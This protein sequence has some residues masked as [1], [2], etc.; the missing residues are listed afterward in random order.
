MDHIVSP[1]SDLEQNAT[2]HIRLD[3]NYHQEQEQPIAP[4]HL[5]QSKTKFYTPINPAKK[6]FLNPSGG[7]RKEGDQLVIVQIDN[8]SERHPSSQ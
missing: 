3:D 1:A 5:Y 2:Q 8:G 4:Q 6:E 7:V